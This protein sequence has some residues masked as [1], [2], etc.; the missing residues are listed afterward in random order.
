MVRPM[1]GLCEWVEPYP[2]PDC[3][4]FPDTPFPDW[5]WDLVFSPDGSMLAMSGQN[6]PAVVVWDTSTGEII[7]TPT[8]SHEIDPEWVHNAAFSPDGNRLVASLGSE[9]WMFSTNDWSAIG[10]Y[11]APAT[12]EVPVDNLTFTPDGETL[13]STAPSRFGPGDI[14]FMDGTTLEHLGQIATAHPGGVNDLGLN[15]DGTLLASAG[16]DGLVRVWDVATRSLLHQI[17]VSST[18]DVGG[19]DF[20]GDTQHLLVTALETGELRKVTSDTEELLEIARS[21]E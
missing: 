10:Q 17:P 19:A 5:P 7:A 9:L 18:G 11:L 21:S 6:T 1:V 20:V 3:V 2:G 8:V 14:V 16:V 4:A 12:G 13:M 15:H